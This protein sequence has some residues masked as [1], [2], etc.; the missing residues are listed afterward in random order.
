MCVAGKE[1]LETIKRFDMPG[2]QPPAPYVHEMRR[3][4]VLPADPS[5]AGLTDMYEIDRAYWRSFEHGEALKN[6]A[7]AVQVAGAGK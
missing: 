5:V 3:Y 4:G 7:Y 6:S 2:F 1:R